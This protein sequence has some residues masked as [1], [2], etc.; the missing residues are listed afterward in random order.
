MNF[1]IVVVAN[2]HRKPLILDYLNNIPHIVS[3][4]ED[5]NLPDGWTVNPEYSH[6]VQHM[7]GHIG[8][9]RCIEGHKSALKKCSKDIVLV[10]EDDAV[11]NR[12]EWLDIAKNSIPLL[13]KH[14]LV[15]LH[16]RSI[17]F[18]AFKKFPFCP[19][20]KEIHSYSA[21]SGFRYVLGSLA[22]LIKME[23][24]NK[25]YQHNYDGFGMDLLIANHFNF[26]LIDPS[27]FNHD[28][29]QGSLIDIGV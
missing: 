29:S 10:L 11:P 18:K 4:S 23:Y 13:S 1:E 14:E 3:Y 19:K 17:D 21:K 16:G 15:S 24:A 8:H 22:Y 25:I 7:H 20:Y 28:R 5:C 12:K 26:G 6:L 2:H 9:H 27:P